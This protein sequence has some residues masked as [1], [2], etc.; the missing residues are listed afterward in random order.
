MIITILGRPKSGKTSL[1]TELIDINKAENRLILVYDILNNYSQYPLF[2]GKSLQNVTRFN[3]IEHEKFFDLALK[4]KNCTVVFDEIDLAC[5]A[6][7]IDDSLKRIINYGRN[8]DIN[9]S[10]ICAARRAARV[11]RDLTACSTK[12][13]LFRTREP[14][15]LK[16]ISDT[17]SPDVIDTIKTLPPYEYIIY[18]LDSDFDPDMIIKYNTLERKA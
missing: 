7:K 15:D 16:F 10:L 8:A 12:C 4:V 5:N 13:I 6:Y 11:N 14:A 2:N 18:D 9:V 1:I 17:V 3:N